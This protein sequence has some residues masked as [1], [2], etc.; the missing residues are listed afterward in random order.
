MYQNFLSKKMSASA[1]VDAAAKE[2]RAFT[3]KG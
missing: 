3:E 2:I 1:A